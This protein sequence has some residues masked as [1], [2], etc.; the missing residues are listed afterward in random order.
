M[1]LQP[2]LTPSTIHPRSKVPEGAFLLTNKYKVMYLRERIKISIMRYPA[3]FPLPSV[4]IYLKKSGTERVFKYLKS[5]CLLSATKQQRKKVRKTEKQHYSL[6]SLNMKF[7]PDDAKRNRAV[8]VA[9]Q[10]PL[11][12]FIISRL[13][14]RCCCCCWEGGEEGNK[15]LLG[16]VI[17]DNPSQKLSP[18]KAAREKR[19]QTHGNSLTLRAPF[20]SPFAAGPVNVCF[21]TP[22]R[23]EKRAASAAELFILRLKLCFCVSV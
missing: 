15:I 7:V 3:H 14:G 12:K 16:N 18:V 23:N 22:G 4:R 13:A 8:M 11:V 20:F 17:S 1:P 19:P 9:S 10:M 21:A 2:F 5:F 6:S